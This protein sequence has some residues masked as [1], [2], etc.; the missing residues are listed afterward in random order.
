[1]NLLPCGVGICDRKNVAETGQM[2]TITADILT[3]A[4]TRE[5]DK[6]TLMKRC[7]QFRAWTRNWKWWRRS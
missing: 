1:M 6:T 2:C 4:A 5:S 3:R 7:S